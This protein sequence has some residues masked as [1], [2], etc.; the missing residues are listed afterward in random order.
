MLFV[1][2]IYLWIINDIFAKTWITKNLKVQTHATFSLGFSASIGSGRW[3]LGLPIA[4]CTTLLLIGSGH[5]SQTVDHYALWGNLTFGIFPKDPPTC[6]LRGSRVIQFSN[7]IPPTKVSLL[8]SHN[9]VCV[10]DASPSFSEWIFF[11][12]MYLLCMTGPV[13]YSNAMH[14]YSFFEKAGAWTQLCCEGSH[15]YSNPLLDMAALNKRRAYS[16]QGWFVFHVFFF[17]FLLLLLSSTSSAYFQAL[18]GIYFTSAA[19]PACPW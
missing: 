17:F 3:L 9:M 12:D 13:T 14:A 16:T 6:C 10:G 1:P 2:L 11:M 8:H 18:P 7:S 19:G 5:H 15:A 4:R